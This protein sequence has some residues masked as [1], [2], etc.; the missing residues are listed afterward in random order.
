[1]TMTQDSPTAERLAH[2]S[3]AID[4]ADEDELLP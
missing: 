4:R 2:A 3:P 1:M